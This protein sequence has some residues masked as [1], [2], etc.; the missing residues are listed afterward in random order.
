MEEL[1]SAVIRGF[2]QGCVYALVAVGFVLTYKTSGVFNLAFGAQAFVSAALYWRLHTDP[3]G[4][5]W[6]IVPA[7][8][9]SVVIAAP[10][11]G[12]VLDRALYRHLRTASP[13]AKLV[14]SLGLLVAL[15]EIAKIVLDMPPQ[16]YGTEGIVPDGRVVYRFGD[17]ALNRD[18]IVTIVVVILAVAV[19]SALFRFTALGLRMRAVVESPRMTELAGVNADRVGSISWML[20]SFFAGV[21]GVLLAPLFPYLGADQYFQLVVTAVAAAVLAG[22]SS[23]PVALVGG[24]ALSVVSQVMVTY[25]PQDSFVRQVLGPALPFVV[26]FGVLVFMP[27]LQRRREAT[28]PLAGV[29]PPPPALAADERSRALTIGTYVFGAVVG[30]GFFWWVLTVANSYWLARFTEAVIYA[31]IFCSITVIT[32]MTGQVSLCQPAFAA[33]GAFTTAQLVTRYDMSVLA[34]MVIGALLAALTGG[35]LS[36]PALRLGGIFLALATLAFALFFE[37]VLVKEE[38]V[39]G[40]ASLMDVPRPTIGPWDFGDDR[41]FFVLCTVVLVVVG[42]LVIFVRG[43]TTGRYLDALRGS[44]VA[45]AAIGINPA[46]LR[47]TAFALSAAIAGVGGGLIAMFSERFGQANYDARFSVFFGLVWTVIVV[48]IGSRTVEGAIQAGAAFIL[49]PLVILQR[50]LPWLLNL[51]LPW[52]VESL[53]TGLTFILFGLG[54]ITYAKHPEG[55]VE[56][57]KRRSLNAVQRWIDRLGRGSVD[58]PPDTVEPAVSLPTGSER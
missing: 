39:G 22:L 38:W 25:P 37:R 8:F 21:A 48:S 10:L 13:V 34:A 3:E 46:R 33:I 5:Q 58:T 2:P 52:H 49:F 54:A 44:E 24:L 14:T 6:P 7:A 56:F 36:I 53:P 23:L 29:D 1:V 32:G 47:I 35:L 27:S 51:V 41:A 40:G 9:V 11:L 57:G 18:D 28:D 26:L 15:P 20:S 43:G 4:W 16:A 50:F 30:L 12:F 42:T 45:A 55:S 31:V 17:Y 19:L